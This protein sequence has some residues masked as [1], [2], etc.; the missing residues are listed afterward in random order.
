MTSMQDLHSL[1]AAPDPENRC[2]VAKLLAKLW[3]ERKLKASEQQA[4]EKLLLL[5]ARD[6]AVEV[7]Q[8]L[9]QSMQDCRHL[10]DELGLVLAL[11]AD[12]ENVAS[13]WLSNAL[14][15]EETLE[16]VIN[17]GNT[18]RQIAI[19]H[20]SNLSTET[21]AH[22]VGMGN[23]K[24]AQTLIENKQSLLAES[25]LHGIL[26][27]Y[28]ENMVIHEHLAYRTLPPSF[29]ERLL[30]A[31]A[32]D[33]KEQLTKQQQFP[34]EVIEKAIHHSR[35]Q[36]RVRMLHPGVPISHIKRLVKHLYDAGKLTD[37]IMV[38]AA[39]TG[40][41]RFLEQALVVKSKLPSE[42]IQRLLFEGGKVAIKKLCEKIGMQPP[43][44]LIIQEALH[45]WTLSREHCNDE[46][47]Q[48]FSRILLER[49]LT[50]Q[51][52]HNDDND[53]DLDTMISMFEK[54]GQLS[55]SSM[56]V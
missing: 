42:N 53:N 52:V 8:A 18:D 35:E 39:C 15:D 36:V 19:A 31:V 51:E 46:D 40:D 55:P 26:D 12:I 11:D 21:S 30:F 33:I 45:N 7:R 3:K 17:Q 37:L 4:V 14:L 6:I 32:D 9:A 41:M 29:A 28:P 38:R 16:E 54:G 24:V 25:T 5:A 43:L 50:K 20:R 2:T 47:H 44:V 49:L 34:R 56:A 22:L 23:V 1:F 27:K 13:P 48:H 10:P